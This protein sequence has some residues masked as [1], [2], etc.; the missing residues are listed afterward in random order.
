MLRVAVV[1]DHP[2]FRSGLCRLLS[3]TGD[4]ELAAEL[5]T[6]DGVSQNPARDQIGV[7]VVDV[8]LPD[9][10]GITLV[11]ELHR[12]GR[13]S[14]VLSAYEDADHVA[15]AFAAGA[16][17]YCTKRDT[18]EAVL[19]A[20]RTVGSGGTWVSPLLDRR[21]DHRG[22]RRAGMAALSPRERAVFDLIVRGRLGPE[23]AR[24]LGISMK[25]V[26]THRYNI[27]R[28]LGVRSVAQLIRFAAMSG[29]AL[30]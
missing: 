5:D 11:D 28:K 8:R 3:H 20:I 16:S 30:S 1:D 10:D 2:V 9:R 17:G 24:T 21:T 22:A 13:R 4:L 27:S 29:F 15:R 19:E 26:E 7:F 23:I 18:P 25:T 6:A 14:L 12:Q